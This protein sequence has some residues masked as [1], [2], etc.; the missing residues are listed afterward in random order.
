[1]I[2]AERLPEFIAEMY[3]VANEEKNWQFFLHKV[4]EGSYLDFKSSLVVQKPPTPAEV[5]ATIKKSEEI[6][7]HF[8]P[9]SQERG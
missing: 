4:L 7:S 6:L 2:Y 3:E 8:V 5:N 9:T 1:M